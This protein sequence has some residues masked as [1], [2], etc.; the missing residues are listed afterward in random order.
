MLLF[1]HEW[2]ELPFCRF[3]DTYGEIPRYIYDAPLLEKFRGP[4]CN[5]DTKR[6]HIHLFSLYI[7]KVFGHYNNTV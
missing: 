7:V 6:G 5:V 3:C 2:I 1:I 4:V